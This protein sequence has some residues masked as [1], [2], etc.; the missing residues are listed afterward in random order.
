MK[1]EILQTVIERTVV[2]A[3]SKEEALKKFLAGETIPQ[4]EEVLDGDRIVVNEIKKPET[5]VEFNPLTKMVSVFEAELKD[6]NYIEEG[7]P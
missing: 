2:T 4:S 3:K 5:H 7:K 6:S 1:F